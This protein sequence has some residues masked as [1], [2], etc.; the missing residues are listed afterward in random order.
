[1]KRKKANIQSGDKYSRLT[2]IKEIEKKQYNRQFLCKCDCGNETTVSSS[3]LLKGDA[4]SCGCLRREV[5]AQRNR[6]EKT[7]HGLSKT[8]VYG[9]WE[10]MLSRCSNSED[11]NYCNYGA[12]GIKVCDEWK[13]VTIFY[14][15]AI[16][17]GH[18]KGLTIERIDNDGNYEPNNCKWIPRK[19]QN[20]NRRM[21]RQITYK[22][23]TKNLTE[24][25]KV[26]GINRKTLETR[27]KNGWV[28]ERALTTPVRTRQ[29]ASC[30]SSI[31]KYKEEK[32]L[33]QIKK[34]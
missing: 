15:W 31:I 21:N 7:T 3:Q 5:T 20:K 34:Q 19:D 27:L 18:Q 28:V 8:R 24:W 1:M 12:R 2:I 25:S 26:T 22:G 16:S 11:K 32:T 13:D 9:I 29:T 4:K 6:K 23:E 33:W 30:R 14:D 17:N 10:R